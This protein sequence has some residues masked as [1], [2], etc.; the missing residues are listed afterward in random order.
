MH[1]DVDKFLATTDRWQEELLALREILLDCQLVEH[2]KWRAPCYSFG[3]KNIAIL[4]DFKDCCTL[5]FFNGALLADPHDLLE[6]PGENTRSA[7]VIR[8]TTLAEIQERKEILRSYIMAAIEVEKAGLKPRFDEHPQ[9][10]LP[11]ELHAAFAQNPKLKSAFYALTPGRQ[12]GYLLHFSGGKQSK[13]RSARIERYAE[14][15][16]DGK[17]LNDCVCGL[18]RKLP[19]CDGSHSKFR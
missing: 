9:L 19:G 2:W 15:I 5:G 16:L 17:G 12:R 18:S 1:S 3:K 6:K 14:R 13:T 4:G 10:D 11:E 7:R 8:F